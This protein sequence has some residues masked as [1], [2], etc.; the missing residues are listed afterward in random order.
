MELTGA[1]IVIECLKEQGVDTVFGFP[2]GAILNVY[3]ELYKHRDEI[4]H[5]LTSHEQG[6]SHAADGYAR[7][8]AVSYTHLFN[9][10]QVLMGG[11]SIDAT[12]VPLTDEAIETCKASDA[13][14]LGSIG[15]DTTTSPWYKLE[16]SLRP[17]AGLLKLRK[18]LGL[19]ANIR[20]AYL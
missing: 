14:L 4:T 8:T 11:C 12:G 19:F 9:Y 16:P 10:T 3:D 5:Y 6:A 17:E 15:G 7:A 18:S 2:G 13:V 20:P 1:Q